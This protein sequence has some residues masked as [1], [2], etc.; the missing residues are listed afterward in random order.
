MSAGLGVM[1]MHSNPHFQSNPPSPFQPNSNSYP[2]PYS[3]PNPPLHPYSNFNP[4]PTPHPYSNPNLQ[5]N[6]YFIHYGDARIMEDDEDQD[7]DVISTEDIVR[8]VEK[9]KMAISDTVVGTYID[10]YNII[11]LDLHIKRKLEQDR[12]N[13][14]N[15]IKKDLEE[16]IRLRSTPQSSIVRNNQ[17]KKERALRDELQALSL[18]ASLINYVNETRDLLVEYRTLRSD[19]KIIDLNNKDPTYVLEDENMCARLQVIDE[20]L[21]IAGKYMT[22]S[23]KR[24][25]L[26]VMTACTGCNTSMNG[27]MA[28][29]DG[30]KFCPGCSAEH[31]DL[32]FS[33]SN[34]DGRGVSTTG[35]DNN[36]S[37]EN[38]MRA[39]DRYQGL[40]PDRPPVSLG[41]ELDG[42]FS[43]RSRP[44]G[45]E[46]KQ[47]P[48]NERGLRGDTDHR[49]LREALSGIGKSEYYEDV[50][51]IGHE[52]FG[53]TLPNVLHLKD[54]IRSNYLKK[55]KVYRNIPNRDRESSLGTQFRLWQELLDCGHVCYRDEFK[56]PDDPASLRNHYRLWN[57]MVSRAEDTDVI[58][59]T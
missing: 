50:N 34:K 41:T 49:M 39:F 54:T 24:R 33:K 55:Q 4:P 31:P 8:H 7:S 35:K 20:Y 32:L 37:I 17:L 11:E 51:L 25:D 5:P 36:D 58:F 13:K 38:F 16:L 27:V 19:V 42:Y 40:Q 1:S 14:P 2:N 59:N 45:S 21:E 57:I 3:N 10:D 6:S 12:L 18:N 9:Q 46:V 44:I 26:K 15:Q 29:E 43:K 52:Y 28:N 53:W 22:L 30:I 48:L 56:I 23:I 47:M